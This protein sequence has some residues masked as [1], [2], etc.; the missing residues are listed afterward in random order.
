M[1]TLMIAG[2]RKVSEHRDA[3]GNEQGRVRAARPAISPEAPQLIQC[4]ARRLEQGGVGLPAD[5]VR[6]SRAGE[7]KW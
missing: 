6:A 1:G 3:Q 4:M 5:M 7:L 2:N